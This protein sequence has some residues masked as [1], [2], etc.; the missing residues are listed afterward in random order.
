MNSDDHTDAYDPQI[1]E[2]F[3]L[4]ERLVP[5]PEPTASL[6]GVAPETE[7]TLV[8]D[9]FAQPAELTDAG[10]WPSRRHRPAMIAVAAAAAVIAG[11]SVLALAGGG[12]GPEL[13]EAGPADDDAELP[14]STSEPATG[15]AADAASDPAPADEDGDGGDAEPITVEV[16]GDT[17]EDAGSTPTTGTTLPPTSATSETTA[18]SSSETSLDDADGDD[19]TGSVPSKQTTVPERPT[20][21][22]IDPSKSGEMVTIAGIVAEVFRDCQSWLVLNSD[23]EPESRPEVSCDGGSFVV[24]DGQRIQT[25]SGYVAAADAFDKHPAGVQPGDFVVVTAINGPYGGLTL[26]CDGCGVNR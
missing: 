26:N 2:R 8:G 4:F 3:A 1:A 13:V 11:V 7:L 20:G 24:V 17:D 6:D 21:S 15:S 12:P 14:V 23:G 9:T 10:R 18:A 5:P 19:T 16:P 22:V 25:T